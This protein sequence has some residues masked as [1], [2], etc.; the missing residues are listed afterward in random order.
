MISHSFSL[1]F[2]FLQANRIC[3]ILCVKAVG[4]QVSKV[5]IWPS[6]VLTLAADGALAFLVSKH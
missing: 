6:P 4:S 1:F 2:F 3:S 5:S